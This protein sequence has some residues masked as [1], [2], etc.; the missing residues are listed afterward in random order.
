MVRGDG[1][2]KSK[3][4]GP[5]C[6]RRSATVRNDPSN[7]QAAP[8][9]KMPRSNSQQL[10]RRIG[11]G[12]LRHRRLEPDRNNASCTARRTTCRHATPQKPRAAPGIM[13]PAAKPHQLPKRFDEAALP[14]QPPVFD[15]HS[16]LRLP[17]RTAR[18]TTSQVAGIQSQ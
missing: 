1:Q 14:N 10:E 2:G 18:G 6:T 12:A 15:R 7:H 13:L 11:N 5:E 16:P 4:G 3:P 8:P 9:I 17:L